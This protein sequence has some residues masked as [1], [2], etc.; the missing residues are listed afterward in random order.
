MTELLPL[1]GFVFVGLFSPGPNVIML[2]A[3]GAQFGFTR[4]LPHILGVA[5][6]VG[7]TSGITGL[8][9]G[10]LLAA[11]PMLAGALRLIAGVWILWMAYALWH[12]QP[13]SV[14][15]GDRPFTFVQALLFQWVN[16]KVWAV[17]FS[18]AAYVADLPPVQGAATLAATFSTLNLGVCL[19]WAFAGSLLA[20]LLTNPV[21]WRL[22]MRCMALALVGFSVMVFL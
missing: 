6:G 1:F 16:P 2:T 20:Y 3:S 13:A 9:L 14:A 18:A 15:A 10:A 17:A 19:F 5:L 4:T 7:V 21:I 12:R 11:Q 8:G 22:F